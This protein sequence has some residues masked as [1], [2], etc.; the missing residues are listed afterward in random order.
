MS[1]WSSAYRD[2][3]WQQKRLQIMER[4]EFECKS[5]GKKGENANLCVHHSFYESGK[6]PWEYD[7][8]TLTTLCEECHEKTH[9]L[10][11]RL[12]VEIFM[13]SQPVNTILELLGYADEG[14]PQYAD[15][16]CY[17]VGYMRRQIQF[18]PYM[19]NAFKKGTAQ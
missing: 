1:K 5:C 2:S 6:A 9:D 8:Y 7:D 17:M 16:E 10:M 15:N 13:S 19:L 12:A 3:R 11:K 18:H 14:I 4:D